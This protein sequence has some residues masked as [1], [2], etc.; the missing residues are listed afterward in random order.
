MLNGKLHRRDLSNDTLIIGEKGVVNATVRAGIV[1]VSGEVVGNILGGE[2]V[3]L[4]G[5][6]RVYG[7]V[8]AP[9]VVARGRR[10]LPGPLPDDQAPDRRRR[11]AAR[12]LRPSPSK[13]S[14]SSTSASSATSVVS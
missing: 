3:E 7:D 14:I 9:V 10:A 8:E 1:L 6:A 5:T 4:R 2:R 11:D 12:P 13:R